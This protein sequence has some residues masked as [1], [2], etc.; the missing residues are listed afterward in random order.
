MN[1]EIIILGELLINLT[2]E[3][4]VGMLNLLL[5]KIKEEK[6]NILE[7][8]ID[9]IEDRI[10]EIKGIKTGKVCLAFDY[11]LEILKQLLEKR[12]NSK[13]DIKEKIIDDKLILG[14]IFIGKDFIFD[15]SFKKF[16]SKIKI[17]GR[18]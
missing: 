13:I 15:F 18:P 6:I 14:G 11:D 3:K 10:K 16:I 7:E 8:L 5:N 1:K 2:K 17:N 4:K 9:Y 12:L